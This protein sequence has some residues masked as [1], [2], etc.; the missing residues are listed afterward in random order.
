VREQIWQQS[1]HLSWPRSSRPYSDQ[2]SSSQDDFLKAKEVCTFV[3][4]ALEKYVEDQS[5]QRGRGVKVLVTMKEHGMEAK[6]CSSPEQQKL[7]LFARQFILVND[8][9]IREKSRFLNSGRGS[10]IVMNIDDSRSL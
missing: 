2:Q 10:E 5:I 7:I 6:N 4:W 1:P 8:N 9:A 3:F